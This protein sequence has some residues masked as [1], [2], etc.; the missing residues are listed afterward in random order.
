MAAKELKRPVLVGWSMGGR[1]IRQYLINYG[2]AEIA[3]VNFVASQVIE[4]PQLPRAR[5][6]PSPCPTG[7]TLAEEI[8]AAIAFL[9]GCFGKKPSE[10]VFRRALGLQRARAGGGAP[11]DRRLV[12]R[13]AA[14]DRCAAHA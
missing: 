6:P 7:L 9:D 13:R 14:H 2:D 5:R 3:G 10:A 4:E 11:G 12:D 1:V 8:D